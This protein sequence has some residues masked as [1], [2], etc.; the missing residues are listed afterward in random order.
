MGFAHFSMHKC[1]SAE[2]S[3]INVETEPRTHLCDGESGSWGQLGVVTNFFLGGG[4]AWQHILDVGG[5]FGGG[6]EVHN[7]FGVGY[8]NILGVEFS[9]PL[10]LLHLTCHLRV[11]LHF[12]IFDQLI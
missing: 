9:V 1:L 5:K 6:G 2:R 12:V 8:Q 10:L 4:M 11:V 3:H 7:I